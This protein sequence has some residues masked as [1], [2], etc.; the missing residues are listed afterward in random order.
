MSQKWIFKPEPDEEIVDG[1]ISSLGFGTLESRLLV[2]RGIDDY[3]S[4]RAF[5]RFFDLL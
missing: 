5:S 1:L 3:Q 4:A 2:L